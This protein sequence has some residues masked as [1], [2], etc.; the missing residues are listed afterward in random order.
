MLLICVWGVL[1]ELKKDFIMHEIYENNVFDR[2][3]VHSVY[4]EG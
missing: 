1:L 2:F 3:V 4:D